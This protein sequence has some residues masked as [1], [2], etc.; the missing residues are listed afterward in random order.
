[1]LHLTAEEQTIVDQA[2]AIL[3]R[4]MRHAGNA[5]TSPN[6]VRQYLRLEL[7]NEINEWFSVV[8]LDNQHRVIT[9]KRLFQGSIS[10]AS[11]HTR[12]IVQESLKYNAAALVVAHNHPSG[13][14]EPSDADVR[15]TRVIKDALSL[16]DV[17]MLDHLVVCADDVTSFAERGLL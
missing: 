7:G 17:R 11:V 12:V 1:M 14:S 6:A 13:C 5:L 2:L 8:F 10:S 4:H 15:L 3:E 9:F 16:I